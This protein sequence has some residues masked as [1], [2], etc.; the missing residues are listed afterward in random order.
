MTKGPATRTDFSLTL[1]QHA[2]AAPL[3]K[4]RAA[5]AG[6]TVRDLEFGDIGMRP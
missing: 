1:R 3:H 2:T 5:A 4:E 6:Q